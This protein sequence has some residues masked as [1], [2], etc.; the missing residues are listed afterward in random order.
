MPT[1]R[2]RGK[3]WYLCWA[4]P[5]RDPATGALIEHRESLGPVSRA[6]AQEALRLKRDELAR[7]RL[8]GIVQLPSGA[9]PTF[10]EFAG[11]YLRWHARE[12]P[13]SH[14]RIAQIVEQYLV[15]HFGPTALDR[16]SKTQAERYKVGR[17]AKAETI[18]KELRTLQ[19]VMN[20]A[21]YLEL[22]ARNPVKGIKPPRNL[23]SKPPRWYTADELAAIYA[24]AKPLPGDEAAKGLPVNS[25]VED[26]APVWRLLANTGLRRA[27]AL[28]LRWADV[29]ENA[30]RVL[31]SEGSRTKSGRWRQVPLSAGALA[32][33]EQLRAVTGR[34]SHVLPRMHEGS[35]S[36]AFSAALQRAGLDGSLHCLRHTFCSHLVTQGVP[37][38]TV[39]VLAG[40]ANI[41]TTERYAHAAPD[42]L[43]AS[44][45][46]LDL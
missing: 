25:G 7:S 37:L 17:Q 3:S 16:I 35:L 2:P 8:A 28:Q 6:F 31:S 43:Q 5:D 42:Y 1:I 41:T 44:V 24:H 39:Q 30:L 18:A 45:A 12:Y 36:R 26:Y 11:E 46:G 10:T 13:S 29:G 32:A 14:E 38:R 9:V 33:L 23:D 20:R 15:P 22:I 27:E 34:T 4:G 19:A 21:V 40:H